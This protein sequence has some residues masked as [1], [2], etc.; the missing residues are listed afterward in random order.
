MGVI[1]LRPVVVGDNDQIAVGTL[2]AREGDGSA[3][4][5]LDGG[6]VAGLDIQT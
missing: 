3:V 1:G 2:P 5:C 4:R 6:A